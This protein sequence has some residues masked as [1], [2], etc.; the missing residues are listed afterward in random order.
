MISF[1][2]KTTITLKSKRQNKCN[3]N[4]LVTVIAIIF[5]QQF[6]TSVTAFSIQS[7]I[8]AKTNTA[9]FKFSKNS[10]T[11][12]V[13]QQ[14]QFGL[15]YSTATS[16]SS[17]STGTGTVPD[18]LLKSITTKGYGRPVQLGDVTTVKYS[19]YLAPTDDN[20]D[21]KISI[22]FAKSSY[23]KVVVG[24]G[25]MID[26]WDKALRTMSVGERSIIRI[27]DSNLAYGTKGVQPFIPSNATIEM[28]IEVLDSVLAST[29]ID[30]DSLAN[31]ADKTPT[32]AKDIANAYSVRQKQRSIDEQDKVQLEGIDYWI[33]KIKNF[34]FYGLF[35]GET[36]ERPPWFLRPSI[37]FPIAFAIVGAAFYVSLIGGAISERGQQSR[38]ELDEIILTSSTTTSS[39]SSPT[40]LSP[41]SDISLLS[42][43]RSTTL[44]DQTMCM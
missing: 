12:R 24:D 18:G 29:N 27:T 37:T 15:L 38:D 39:S 9:S 23:Q 3:M 21:D 11:Y 1:C 42:A 33:E 34:Y 36:G 5:C 20:T 30:F 44:F 2:T 32:T 13:Q 4:K 7:K 41:I 17:A 8:I 43:A 10:D 25:T 28:D 19:C 14:K 22:P 26:G 16:S 40:T 6:I 31:L 35:E